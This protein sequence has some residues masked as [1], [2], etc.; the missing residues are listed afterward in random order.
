MYNARR[1]DMDLSSYPTLRRVD[2][3]C[4]V[5]PAFDAAHPD[6]QPDAVPPESR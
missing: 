2:A 4:R 6:R 5:L 3:A 1:F